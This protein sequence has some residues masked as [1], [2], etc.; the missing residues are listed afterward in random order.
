MFPLC[1]AAVALAL[2]ATTPGAVPRLSFDQF[3]APVQGSFGKVVSRREQWTESFT[4]RSPIAQVVADYSG[5]FGLKVA[6]GFK[7][8]EAASV[9]PF[10]PQDFGKMAFDTPLAASGGRWLFFPADWK[11]APQARLTLS[12]REVAGVTCAHFSLLTPKDFASI[13]VIPDDEPSRS[14]VI[15]EIIPR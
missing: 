13:D 9:R 10:G 11:S 2:C 15:V 3:R 14:R 7:S 12:Y 5:S 6:D 4:L 8:P 1:F